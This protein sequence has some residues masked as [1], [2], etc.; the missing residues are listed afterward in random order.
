MPKSNA[1]KLAQQKYDQKSYDQILI[2]VRKGKRDEYKEKALELGFGQMEMIRA[3]IEEFIQRHAGEDFSEA[4]QLT[5]T[6]MSTVEKPGETLSLEEKKLLEDFRQMPANL[7]KHVRGLI[8][9]INDAQAE[10]D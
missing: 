5:A 6:S 3:A 2:K 7:Q 10:S 8:Q 4:N 9:A 1:Q